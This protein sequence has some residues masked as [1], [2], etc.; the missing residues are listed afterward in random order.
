MKKQKNLQVKQRL[1]NSFIYVVAI[2][3]IA[4]LL[5][6][7][8]MLVMDFRYSNALEMNGFIQGDLGEYN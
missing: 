6:A 5:G 4:G 2:A 8:L 7:I 3:S 1:T